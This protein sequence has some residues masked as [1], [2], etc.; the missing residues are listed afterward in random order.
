M[1]AVR[2]STSTA[3]LRYRGLA[4]WTL[5][6]CRCSSSPSSSPFGHVMLSAEVSLAMRS[7]QSSPV[8][9]VAMPGYLQCLICRR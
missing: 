9:L 5:L 2:G 1:P 7:L 6:V 4:D 8:Q 3:R